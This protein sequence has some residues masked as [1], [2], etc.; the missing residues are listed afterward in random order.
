MTA[1]SKS[2]F[3]LLFLCIAFFYWSPA[4]CVITLQPGPSQGKDAS[5]FFLGCNTSYAIQTGNCETTPTGN[6]DFICAMGWTF[7]SNYGYYRSFLEFDLDSLAQ[8]GCTVTQ[9]TLTLYHSPYTTQYHCGSNTP[10]HPCHGNELEIR[11]VL[12]PWNEQTITAVNAPGVT[13]GTAPQDYVQD[14][15]QDGPYAD[16][17]FDLTQMVNYWLTNPNDNYGMRFNLVDETN[18]SGRIWSS[19]DAANPALRPRLTLVLNCPNSCNSL[20]SGNIYDDSNSNCVQN[21]NENPLENWL[22]RIDP[23]PT[24]A[25]TNAAGYWQAWVNAGTYTVS[26]YIPNTWLWDSICPLNPYSHTAT[27]AN[28]DTVPNLDFAVHADN[29]CPQLTVDVGGNSLRRC[30][31]EP[32]YVQYCNNGNLPATGVYIDVTLDS[33]LTYLSSEIPF[34]GVNG[35]TYTFWIDTLQPGQCGNFWILVQVS[36]SPPVGEVLCVTAEI[37]PIDTCTG[38]IDPGYDQSVISVGAWCDG[39]SLACFTIYN[40]GPPGTGDMTSA[41]QFRIYE[42]TNLVYTG[43]FQLCGGCDTTICWPASLYVISMGAD[44]SPGYPGPGTTAVAFLEDC[45]TGQNPQARLYFG[46]GD[47]APF[48]ETDCQEI[49]ASCDPNDKTV[50]PL[51]L[52]TQHY[53]NDNEQLEYKIRFQN[54]GNDTAFLVIVRDTLSPFLDITSIL[55]GVSSHPYS[56]RI[57]GN[58][59]LEWTFDPIELPDSNVNEPASHGFLKFKAKQMPGNVPG[60]VIENRVGIYFDINAPVITNTVFNTVLDENGLSVGPVYG[61]LGEIK[62]YPNPVQDQLQI[63][64]S[65]ELSGKMLTLTNLAGK[66]MLQR[67]DFEQGKASLSLAGLAQGIYLLKVDTQTGSRVFKVIK[68]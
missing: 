23:G 6:R 9:A 7:S 56:W 2:L 15:N 3:T 29:Y 4:Q 60:T 8:A 51:G 12:A 16:H 59:I 52:S 19:S 54:T 66:I 61:D 30:H 67:S 37:F 45:G 18:Y 14:P 11:R 68:M 10:Q 20:L 17:S 1:P 57:Y 38:P 24:Y 31:S 25:T 62:V 50:A 35:N 48:M 44:Q 53:I 58:R 21:T 46:Q 63:E 47:E 27:I 36:C 43:T 55:P 22:V 42:G 49:I 32:Y 13:T 65:V 34:S 26:Q 33:D 39:D 5:P 40:Y 28:Q 64:L 41:N